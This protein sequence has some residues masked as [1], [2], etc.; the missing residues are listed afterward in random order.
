MIKNSSLSFAV[1]LTFALALGFGIAFALAPG[2]VFVGDLAIALA[3]VWTCPN[4]AF[5]LDF[6]IY[7]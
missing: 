3:C 6:G 2:F 1:Y 4:L 7:S 5:T